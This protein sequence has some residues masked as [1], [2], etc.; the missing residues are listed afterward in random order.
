MIKSFLRTLALLVVLVGIVGAA[1]AFAAPDQERGVA[2]TQGT[3]ALS[4]DSFPCT[5][6]S[7]YPSLPYACPVVWPSNGKI[8]IYASG[9]TTII[10]YLH[11]STGTQYFA[12]EATG[13]RYTRGS[14]TNIWW[15]WTQGD[16]HGSWGWVPEVFFKGGLNDEPDAGL[17]TC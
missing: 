16:E 9:T 10:D 17:P 1:P 11:S 5:R 2:A 13:G 8:P 6:G 15:A 12:C 14:D 7:P 3:P 4:T